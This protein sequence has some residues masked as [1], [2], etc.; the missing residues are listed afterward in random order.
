LEETCKELGT[1]CRYH[2]H[3]ISEDYNVHWD[4][5]LGSGYSGPVLIATAGAHCHRHDAQIGKRFAV[6]TFDKTQLCAK[7]L[8]FLQ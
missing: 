4:T 8:T 2:T 6:K 1:T 7:K 3:D 5:V